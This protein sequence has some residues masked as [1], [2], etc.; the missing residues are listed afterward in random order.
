M[1]ELL[2]CLHVHVNE[3]NMKTEISSWVY[4]FTDLLKHDKLLSKKPPPAHLRAV[5]EYLVDRTTQE[6]SKILKLA[7]AAMGKNGPTRRAGPNKGFGKTRDP[8]KTFSAEVCSHL[9]L[10]FSKKIEFP[11]I[12]I[13][14]SMWSFLHLYSCILQSTLKWAIPNLSLSCCWRWN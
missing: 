7:R 3:R 13:F 5:P 9:S 10:T 12:C 1:H 4:D 8:L 11:L 2:C 6:A 14:S